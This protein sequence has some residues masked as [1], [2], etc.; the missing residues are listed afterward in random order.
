MGTFRILLVDSSNWRYVIA[1]RA[2]KSQEPFIEPNEISLLESFYDTKNDWSCFGLFNG[3]TAVG[4]MMIGAENREERYVWLD[5]FMIDRRF[6]GKG[7]GGVF[8]EKTKEFVLR[9]Y[10]VDELVLSVTKN[11]DAAKHFYRKHGFKDT[12]LIDPEFDEE[13]YV[14]NLLK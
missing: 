4:F 9:Q 10:D 2:E 13:I 1:L 6:Q 11:N 12:G 8:L 14:Y 5:R 7:L 3:E